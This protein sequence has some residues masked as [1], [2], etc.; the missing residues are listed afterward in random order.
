[1]DSKATPHSLSP[2]L[3]QHLVLI[4]AFETCVSDLFIGRIK[5]QKLLTSRHCCH[6]K[7]VLGDKQGFSR[8]EMSPCG[9]ALG[10]V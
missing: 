5:H 6:F 4:A 3:M 10:F 2:V 8:G 7:F 9:T 1:M